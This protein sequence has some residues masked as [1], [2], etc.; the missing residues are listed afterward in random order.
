MAGVP[1]I[2]TDV[3]GSRDLLSESWRGQV[4]SAGD[5][6]ALA[7]ALQ[8]WIERGPLNPELSQRIA[9]WA[10]CITG[11]AGAEYLNAILAHLRGQGPRPSPPWAAACS[12]LTQPQPHASRH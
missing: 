9:T 5:D 11:A 4:V 3:C 6:R 2:C 8:V 12:D 10:S 1:C 7:S